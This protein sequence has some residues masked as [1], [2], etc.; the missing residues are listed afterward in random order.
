[1]MSIKNSPI[2]LSHHSAKVC[3][4]GLG[5]VGLSLACILAAQGIQVIG[6]DSN[7]TIIDGLNHNTPHFHEQGLNELLKDVKDQ[8]LIKFYNTNQEIAEII[9]I[10]II[11]VSTPIDVNMQPDLKYIIQVTQFISK[12]LKPNDLV[13][14]RS[15]L[16]VGTLRSTIMPILQ[17]SNLS[18]GKEFFLAFAPERTVQGN[19]LKELQSLPQIIG[20][21]DQVSIDLTTQLF[22]SITEDIV[23]VESLEAAEM[24]KLLN[25]TY[26][27]LRFAFAN[28]VAIMCDHL[29]LNAFNLIEAANYKYPRD[30]IP[31]PSP[32]VG[33]SCLSKDSHLYSN[34]GSYHD[35][36]PILGKISRKINDDGHLYVY[37]KINKYCNLVRKNIHEIKILIIGIAFKG[38]PETSDT[39]ESM[40]F[41]L[42]EI[43]PSVQNIYIKDFVNIERNLVLKSCNSVE[44]IMDGFINVDIALVMNNHPLNCKFDVTKAISSMQPAPLFFD[45]WNQFSQKHVECIND[46]Y[47]ATMGYM[48]LKPAHA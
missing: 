16:P 17:T 31:M 20:G 38:F 6:V 11:C 12:K 28:E 42:I 3:I 9:D 25:N 33:G 7:P 32:G 35:Y 34:F 27:D 44:N 43:L 13:I 39:R 21:F 41:K 36:V 24:I 18:I 22:R 10:H 23:I 14:Y 8:N 4:Y 30:P 15:T 46:A 26:R 40:A 48:T 19:T 37:E 47:Y 5:F 45:G 1:M 2:Q 29:N